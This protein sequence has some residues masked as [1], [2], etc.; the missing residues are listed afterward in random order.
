MRHQDTLL[1]DIFAW[2]QCTGGNRLR[3]P[4]FAADNINTHLNDWVLWLLPLNSSHK[5]NQPPA[6]EKCPAILCRSIRSVSCVHFALLLF[7]FVQTHNCCRQFQTFPSSWIHSTLLGCLWIL[8]VLTI[9]LKATYR[10]M[11][12]IQMVSLMKN[13]GFTLAYLIH[14]LQLMMMTESRWAF[15]ITHTLAGY[16]IFFLRW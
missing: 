15:S 2:V 1:R 8:S 3:R 6:P 7:C 12:L 9:L 4:N 10:I 14:S 11:I 16:L 13:F 5:L